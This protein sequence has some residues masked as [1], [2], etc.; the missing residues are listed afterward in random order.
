MDIY[1][2]NALTIKQKELI[3]SNVKID[4]PYGNNRSR[5]VGPALSTKIYHFF[6]CEDGDQV[7]N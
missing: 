1:Q 7:V 4:N 3:L 6:T 5:N 2:N